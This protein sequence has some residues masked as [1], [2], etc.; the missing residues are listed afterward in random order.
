LIDFNVITE[1]E[2]HIT[3]EGV[4]NSSAKVFPA[5][6]LLMAMF[7]QGV[8]RGKVA[9][10]GKDAAFNQAC[11]AIVPNGG[12]SSRYLF[13]C[14]AAKYEEIRRLSNSGSQENLNAAIIKSISVPV[15]PRP[16]QDAIARIGDTWDAR[17]V[18]LSRLIDAKDRARRGLMQQLLTGKRRF[19]EF[20]GR[21]QRRRLGEF[22]VQKNERN[23]GGKVGLVLSVTNTEGFV[24]SDDYFNG[25]VYSEN[26]AHYKVVRPGWFAFN[27]SRVNVGS[28]A[29]LKDQEPGVLSPMYIVFDVHC[30]LLPEYLEQWLDSHEASE[31]IRQQAAGSVRETVNFTNFCGIP[32]KL[33]AIE[34]QRKIATVLAT[35]D[36][37][38]NLLKQELNLLKQQKRG[39]MQKLLTG[40]IRVKV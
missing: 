10:L 24:R 39:L 14:L 27:P 2:E 35:A 11:V 26:T 20:T 15:P 3:L 19:P 30:G 9:V 40:R 31:H 18:G 25:R 17:A 1:T 38:I 23:E 36:R 29:R 7:G 32:I 28:I 12:A 8:T 33:P 21:W 4:E 34:E 5:G 37:E 22:L 6:T 13:H 16:E